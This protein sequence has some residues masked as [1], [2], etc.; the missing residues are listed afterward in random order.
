[1]TREEA[2]RIA[3]FL[4]QRYPACNVRVTRVFGGLRVEVHGG[5]SSLFAVIGSERSPVLAALKGHL[6]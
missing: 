5:G 6:R 1:M 4:R 2:A 3:A